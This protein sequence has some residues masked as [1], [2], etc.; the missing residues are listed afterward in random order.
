MKITYNS[1]L[2]HLTLGLGLWSGSCT[3]LTKWMR[4]GKVTAKILNV[5]EELMTKCRTI[6]RALLSGIG[7]NINNFKNFCYNVAQLYV[8]KYEWYPMPASVHTILIH[9][10][11]IID[12]A[13]LPIGKLSEDAQ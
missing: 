9:G 8:E 13:P 3:F 1:A 5:D 11:R 2:L 6:L 10:H 4:T 7:I 12:C